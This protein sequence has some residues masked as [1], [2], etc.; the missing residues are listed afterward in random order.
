[1]KKFSIV[2]ILCLL[3]TATTFAQYKPEA[4][5]VTTEIQ[6]NPFNQNGQNFSVDGLKL[7]YFFNENNALR[8]TIG[9]GVY[10][11]KFTQKDDNS[12]SE[13]KT[14]QGNF[15]LNLG[16]EY[17]IDIAPRLSA[18]VGL[19]TGF[20][21]KN[22]KTTGK[23]ESNGTK[24]EVEIKGGALSEDDVND[25]SNIDPSSLMNAGFEYNLGAFAGID[26]YMYKG[27]YCGAEFGL[28]MNTF[29]SKKPSIKVK[30]GTT[31]NEE[32]PNIK[33]NTLD[34]AFKA[35]PTIRL[36]WRF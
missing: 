24:S 25:P 21:I 7:R 5:S 9:F 2:L 34:V 36:G 23:Y 10:N 1:M 3:A 31:V 33:R 27:L 14:R 18:Y 8:A 35:I 17:H 12:S 13:Y 4:G 28:D 20:N 22:A 29:S 15:K 19:Q 26:F 32:K 16:Y 30:Q 6:F 11:N